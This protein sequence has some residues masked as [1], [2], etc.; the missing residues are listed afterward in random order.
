MHQELK[1]MYSPHVH[2]SHEVTKTIRNG[3]VSNQL[4]DGEK[5]GGE[6]VGG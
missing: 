5:W 3:A 4:T 2:V 1:C 6:G